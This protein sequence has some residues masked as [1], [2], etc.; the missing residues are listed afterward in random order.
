MVALKISVLIFT[1]II[2]VLSIINIIFY[3]EAS[4]GNCTNVNTGFATFMLWV[5]VVIVVLTVGL[6]IFSMIRLFRRKK[7]DKLEE[8]MRAEKESGDGRGSYK[9]VNSGPGSR[10]SM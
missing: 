7:S 9:R 8:Q 1:I 5:N 4:K 3:N 2:L 10:E 6:F